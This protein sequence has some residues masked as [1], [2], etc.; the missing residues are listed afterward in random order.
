[1]QTQTKTQTRKTDVSTFD[2]VTESRKW[3]ESV[4][5]ITCDMSIAERMAWF[6]SQSSVPIIRNQSKKAAGN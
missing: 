2:A 3:K 4:A 6:R 1:M 5:A